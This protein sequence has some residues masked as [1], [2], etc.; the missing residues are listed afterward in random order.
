[1]GSAAA[2][3]VQVRRMQ[4]NALRAELVQRGIERARAFDWDITAKLTLEVYEEAAAA[5]RSHNGNVTHG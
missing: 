4:D 2:L 1:V 5:G 3:A